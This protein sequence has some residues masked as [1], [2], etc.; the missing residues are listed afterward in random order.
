VDQGERKCIGDAF[1]V[2]YACV[3]PRDEDMKPIDRVRA[4]H[5]ELTA[6][7]RLAGLLGWRLRLVG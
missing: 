3:L 7:R 1:N 4:Y 6:Q 2:G 5:P